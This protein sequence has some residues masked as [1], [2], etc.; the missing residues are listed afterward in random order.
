M[1]FFGQF[2]N[3]L[4]ALSN[5][6]LHWTVNDV[7]SEI[8]SMEILLQARPS[9]TS[10]NVQETLLC[11]LSS[12]Q[13]LVPSDAVKLY[14]ALTNSKLPKDMVHKM[15]EV[16]D[17]RVVAKDSN[18][19]ATKLSLVPQ[20]CEGLANYL[21]AQ[22]HEDLLA[23]DMYKGATII[24]HRM[25]LLG[26]VS[27]K[28]VTKK[29]AVAILFWYEQQ[30][31]KSVPSPAVAYSLATHVLQVFQSDG[32][33]V[34]AGAKNLACYPLTPSGL[35]A[36]HYKA[37]FGDTPPV[38]IA[39]PEL[40]MIFKNHVKVRN[41]AKEVGTPAQRLTQ[42]QPDPAASVPT[43]VHTPATGCI[44]PGAGSHV[45][46]NMMAQ[47]MWAQWMN[48]GKPMFGQEHGPLH[49]S[50]AVAPEAV[51][52]ATAGMPAKRS[53]APL[54]STAATPPPK[55]TMDPLPLGD[56]TSNGGGPTKAN[57]DQP[58]DLE[59]FENAAFEALMKRRP[60]VKQPVMKR[61]SAKPKATKKTAPQATP[62][63]KAK[64]LQLGCKRCRGTAR[65]CSQC[66]NS[67]YTGPRMNRATWLKLGLK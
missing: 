58:H 64:G 35:D 34:P 42:K 44:D 18:N 7:V 67:K 20:Q 57:D 25:K 23:F 6:N 53:I 27:L 39:M 10:A 32:T 8:S 37:S 30:R 3:W 1:F 2:H 56:S 12:V 54:P 60:A 41:T 47:S 46:A 38:E 17:S 22:D 29:M 40:A 16:V 50:K 15:Q 33:A 49:F 31:T 5:A 65:G 28:E 55:Q 45:L 9:L 36:E 4:M 51:H 66:R 14:E 21:T 52:A 63:P 61:P 48:F 62:Q 13:L 26:L 59:D 24:S 19:G 11:K 43:V